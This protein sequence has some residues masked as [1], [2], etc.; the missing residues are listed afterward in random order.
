MKKLSPRLTKASTT[1]RP[2]APYPSRKFANSC[3]SGLLPPPLH[4]RV[5]ERTT[6]HSATHSPLVEP[7]KQISRHPALL[8]VSR[9]RH[10]QA[11]ARLPA[12]Q[13]HQPKTLDLLVVADPFRRTE[14]PLTAPSQ[15][16]LETVHDV[17][18]DLSEGDPRV[19]KVEVVLPAFQVPVQLLHQ[20]RDRVHTLTM[21]RQL[22]QLLP[23]LLQSL[24][25]RTHM[26]IPPPPTLQ[27][28]KVTECESQKVQ[29]RSFL[30]Q[31]HHARLLPIDLQSQPAFQPRLYPSRQAAA[32]IARQHHKIVGVA[33]QLGPRPLR[34]S[35]GS[36]KL[37]VKP[38]QIQITEQRRNH[39]ALGRPFA[40]ATPLSRTTPASRLDNWTLQPHPDPLEHTP[41][42]YS[43]AHAS[44]KLVVRNRIEIAF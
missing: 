32:L 19:A 41:V 36:M 33:H 42:H 23:F 26:Q 43:H 18:V 35:I 11:V 10:A 34:R 16:L 30:P 44:Q 37:L 17:R 8:K 24:P 1:P 20:L 22:M 39:P 29:T 21:I 28:I 3:H 14:G 6:L 7:D 9:L 12:S 13:A 27:V 15:M 2:A 4:G 40:R 5:G 31:L 38:M 25:R